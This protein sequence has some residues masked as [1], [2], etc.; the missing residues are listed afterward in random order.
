MLFR[1]C[2]TWPPHLVIYGFADSQIEGG[3][4]TLLGHFEK[5]QERD[6]LFPRTAAAVEER[7]T[8]LMGIF[9]CR[10][11]SHVDRKECGFSGNNAGKRVQVEVSKQTV[12]SFLQRFQANF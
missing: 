9:C 6:R 7:S 11:L 4:W 5:A 10:E 1:I 8:G 2:F 3:C 12:S